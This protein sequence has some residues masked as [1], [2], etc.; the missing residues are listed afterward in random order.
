MTTLRNALLRRRSARVHLRD[1]RA[2]AAALAAAPTI[3]S[4]HEI[5][6]LSTRR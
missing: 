3:E 5:A 2:L 1:E 4:A 6:V